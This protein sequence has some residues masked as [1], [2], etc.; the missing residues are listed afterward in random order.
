MFTVWLGIFN[1]PGLEDKKLTVLDLILCI[2]SLDL[3]L[4]VS[5]SNLTPCISGLG[6]FLCFPGIDLTHCIPSVDLTLSVLSLDFTLLGQ[7]KI[8]Y[9]VQQDLL[10][11]IAKF[12]IDPK[13]HVFDPAWDR[14]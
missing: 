7:Q 1:C 3:T 12:R 10:I 5:G 8:I 9:H 11:L 13:F 6:M 14:L 2:S 4:C